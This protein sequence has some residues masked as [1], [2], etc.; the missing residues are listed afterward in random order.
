MSNIKKASSF[1]IKENKTVFYMISQIEENDEILMI[2]SLK[3]ADELNKERIKIL[4]DQESSPDLLVRL[5]SLTINYMKNNILE[6][7]PDFT[8]W[9]SLL[10]LLA[11]IFLF[12]FTAVL[13]RDPIPLIDEIVL[14]CIGG[15][16]FYMTLAGKIIINLMPE[17]SIDKYLSFVNRIQ[18][19]TSPVFIKINEIFESFF[20]KNLTGEVTLDEDKIFLRNVLDTFS[21]KEKLELRD[22]LNILDNKFKFSRIKFNPLQIERKARKSILSEIRFK[23]YYL[24]FIILKN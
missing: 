11:G 19:E 17:K 1:S 22:F 2:N 9:K 21:L 24:L 8:W 16:V 4:I 7:S 12:F 5:K 13:I 10:S 23:F 18:V 20:D 15:W 3:N 6:S 14:S